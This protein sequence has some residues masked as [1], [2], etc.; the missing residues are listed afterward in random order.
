MEIVGN[1]YNTSGYLNVPALFDYDTVFNFVVAGRGTGK[2]F[3]ALKYIYESG[4]TAVYLRRTQKQADIVS[5]AEF[6]PFKP[7]ADLLGIDYFV[8]KVV[9]G[10][11]ALR[12][13]DRTIFYTAALSTFASLRS[14]DMSDVSIIFYDEFI[15]EPSE[16]APIRYE[17]EAFL[18]MYETVNRNRELS[19]ADPVKLFA[20]ANANDINNKI[21]I[22]LGLVSV[23]DQMIKKGLQEWHD[24]KRSVSLYYP[25]AS[26]ISSRKRETALYRLAENTDFA[27]MAIKNS[28]NVDYSDIVNRPQVEYKPIA[29]IGELCVRRHKSRPKEYLVTVGPAKGSAPGYPATEKGILQFKE[30]FPVIVYYWLFGE[31]FYYQNL[32]AKSLFTTYMKEI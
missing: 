15:P 9:P 6:T 14:F 26:P 5:K 19:G 12:T 23:T 29:N 21:F 18:N 22:G 8:D 3:G 17:Y 20:A 13:K 30:K 7:V 32:L 25:A 24:L 27:Q 4:Q 16:K 10:V 11:T 1:L 28:Y 31:C 2:S